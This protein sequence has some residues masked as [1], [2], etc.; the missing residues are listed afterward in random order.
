[1]KTSIS[2]AVAA[3]AAAGSVLADDVLY[4]QRLSKRFIDA[5]GHYNMCEYLT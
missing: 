3:L 5:D 2:C 4:S 1:M